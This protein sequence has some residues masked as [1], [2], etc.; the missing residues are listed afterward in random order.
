MPKP[1]TLHFEFAV[2]GRARSLD[3][4]HPLW[5]EALPLSVRHPPKN[6]GPA[7]EVS[8]GDYFQAIRSYFLKDGVQHLQS[9]LRPSGPTNT[10]SP[11]PEQI[12]VVLEKHGEFYR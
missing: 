8:H 11:S 4:T 1:R 2:A 5:S 12:E 7:G 10:P 6:T 3:E 9:A